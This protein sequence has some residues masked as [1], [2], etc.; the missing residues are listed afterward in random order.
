MSRQRYPEKLK[1]VAIKQVTDKGKSVADVAQRSGMSVHSLYVYFKVY[2]KP[3][4]HRQQDDDQQAELLAQLKR[5][6]K[7]LDPF[8]KS[9]R[10]LCQG[11]WLKSPFIKK[12]S[13]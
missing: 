4:E 1:M 5:V 3:R 6:T 12:H 8:R 7:D 9:L 13:N 11:E 2:N 10:V